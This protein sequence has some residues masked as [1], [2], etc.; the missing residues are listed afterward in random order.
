MHNCT[1]RENVTFGLP[2]EKEK[3]EKVI[4][5]C[6]LQRDLTSLPAGDLTEIG[7]YLNLV[8][9]KSNWNI[10]ARKVLTCLAVKNNVSVLHVHCTKTQTCTCW[11]IVCLPLTRTWAN[12][13]LRTA[14]NKAWRAK[15]SCWSRIS[16]STYHSSIEYVTFDT[17]TLTLTFNAF[18]RW[19]SWRRARSLSKVITMS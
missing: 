12:A 18:Y 19:L 17:L 10:Q 3:Y 6:E 13:S 16:Y 15:L 4:D 1:L 5:L 2:Y 14:S 7:K 11:T 9:K 8:S